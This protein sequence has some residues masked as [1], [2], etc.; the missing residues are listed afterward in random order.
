MKSFTVAVASI[1]ALISLIQPCPAP[2][3]IAIGA[4]IAGAAADA[5]AAVAGAAGAAA[6]AVSG[7]AGAAAGAVSGA[8][9]TA[10]GG[11]AIGG[12]IA[13]GVTAGLDHIHKEKRFRFD[14]RSSTDTF[15]ACIA[16]TP[17]AASKTKLVVGTDTIIVDGKAQSWAAINGVPASCM[18][19]INLYNAHPNITIL[20]AMHGATTIINDTAILLT[21]MPNHYMTYLHTLVSA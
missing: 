15:T 5:G 6:G 21:G 14:R 3:V 2:P 7:A 20:N 18:T 1:I 12:V 11:A 19:Q 4:A 13:G 16:D 9:G 10:A 8:A 17:G